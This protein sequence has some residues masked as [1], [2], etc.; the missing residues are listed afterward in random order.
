MK[1][2]GKPMR[3]IWPIGEAAVGVIDQR[4][5]PH[6]FEQLTLRSS[7]EVIEAIRTMTVRGAPLIGVTGAFGL[8]LAM[9]ADPSDAHLA[10]AHRA[11]LAARPTAVNLRWALERVQATIGAVP[12]GQRATV[13]WA[14]ASH[15]AEDDV[16][17]NRA[18]GVHGAALLRVLHTKLE[19]PIN[20]LTHCN[21][22]WLAAVDYGTALAAIYAA[23]DDGIPLVVWVDETRPR[24][25]G[26]L[27]AW[28]LAAH[29]VP[30]K[31]IV[32]N[33]GG[34]L[35]QHGMVDIVLVGADRV[36]A[37]GDVANKIGTYLKALAAHDN[38]VPF[39]AAVPS[40][41]IDWRVE[42]GSGVDPDRGT[43]GRRSALGTRVGSRRRAGRSATHAARH[44]GRQ[45]GVRRDARPPRHRHHHGARRG[46]SRRACGTVS[47]PAPGGLMDTVEDGPELRR[48]IISTALAM[49]AAGINVNKS[50]NVSARARRGTAQGFVVTPTAVP[51]HHLAASDLAF[52]TLT[53]AAHGELEPSSEWRFH[54]DIYAARP[55]FD[56]DRAYA[57][58]VRHRPRLPRPRHSSLS[59]HGGRRGRCRHPLRRLRHLRHAATVGPRGCRA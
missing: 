53:G 22:G 41:T 38:S 48:A 16:V 7:A 42:D 10:E 15:I 19:R 28:E 37:R 44:I 54:R 43:P 55:E 21:T 36:S 50:G 27:T 35:M 46:G 3:S 26:L 29:G 11:L 57:L 59:L 25:Q 14:E 31:L 18:L 8:A 34:H 12:P 40:P 39:Y 17:L 51:Y 56:G 5:L 23:H 32:D 6:R 52:V 9:R 47:R 13:A 30:H 45:P 24:N 58:A 4:A 1:V 49:N 2:N 20:V 33:A